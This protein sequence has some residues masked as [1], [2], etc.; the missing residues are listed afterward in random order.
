MF[1]VCSALLRPCEEPIANYTHERLIL[2]QKVY[3]SR[4]PL[5]R[6]AL[7]PDSRKIPLTLRILGSRLREVLSF[8]KR[9]LL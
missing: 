1:A 9:A 8:K 5:G 2:Y 7:W 4:S 6:N 3:V